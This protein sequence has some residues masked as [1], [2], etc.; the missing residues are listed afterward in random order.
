MVADTDAINIAF[1]Q[2][3]F[4]NTALHLAVMQSNLD[5]IDIILDKRTFL[6]YLP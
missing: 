3:C 2:D 6:C 4:G 5:A 1:C